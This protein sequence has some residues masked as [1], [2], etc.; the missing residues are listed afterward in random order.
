MTDGVFG[1]TFMVDVMSLELEPEALDPSQVVAGAPTLGNRTLFESDDGR[2][3]RGV[4]ECTPGICKDVE[5]D[6]LFVVVAGHASVVVEGGPT[7]LLAP[8]VAGILERGARTVWTVT[9]TLRKVYQI[10]MPG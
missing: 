2:V 5:Q 8:G 1:T 6:E 7:L 10:S 4:W 9:E 3:I